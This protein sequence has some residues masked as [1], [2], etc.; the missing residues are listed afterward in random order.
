MQHEGV[1]H[2]ALSVFQYCRFLQELVEFLK[3]RK[4]VNTVVKHLLSSTQTR[5]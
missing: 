1:L 5:S 4:L 3:A 2:H